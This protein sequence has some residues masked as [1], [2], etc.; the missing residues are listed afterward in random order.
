MAARQIHLKVQATPWR[1]TTKLGV[2]STVKKGKAVIHKMG[3]G[4]EHLCMY[5]R[6]RPSRKD[7]T[8][9]SLGTALSGGM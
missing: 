3:R 1:L 8:H 7:P 4:Q 5:I 6:Y 9:P 2:G